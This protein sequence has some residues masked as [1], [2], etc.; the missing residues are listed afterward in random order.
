MARDSEM[1]GEC[2]VWSTAQG[3]KENFGCDA[4]LWFE[5]DNKLVGCGKQSCIENGGWPCLDKSLY[6]EVDG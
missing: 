6:F 2:N 3:E 5:G 1:R 4:Y